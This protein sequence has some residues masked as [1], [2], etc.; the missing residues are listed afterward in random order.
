MRCKLE[1][2]QQCGKRV[3]TESH[4]VLAADSYVC[5]SYRGKTGK[6]F[7]CSPSPILNRVS[8][9]YILK[10]FSQAKIC[11]YLEYYKSIYSH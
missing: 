8:G 6:G 2:L 4:K 9:W 3:K 10:S 5:R 11:F 7:F 1:I